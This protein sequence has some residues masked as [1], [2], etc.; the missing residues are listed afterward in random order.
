MKVIA[1]VALIS[2]STGVHAQARAVQLTRKIEMWNPAWSPDG[3]T[4]VFESTLDGESSIYTIRAD[5]S[6]LARLTD[7]SFDSGQ[8]TWSPDGRRIVYSSN[9]D[10]Q[11][12]IY[13]MNADGSAQTKITSMQSGG[14]Y[15]SS[16][17]PDGRLIVFQGRPN[18]AQT[19]DRIY[20]IGAD[21][22]RFKQ[23][24]DTTHG[25]EGPRWSRDGKTI[26]FRWV[27]Y[28]KWLWEQMGPADMNAANAGARRMSIRPDGSGLSPVPQVAEPSFSDPAVPEDA[29]RSP[30]GGMFAYTKNV[31]G[32]NALYIYSI[33]T[34]KERMILGGA[35]A[36][37]V[38][39]LRTANAVPVTDT[40]DTFESP[41]AG[42]ELRRG[43]GASV[44][45]SVRQIGAH[46]WET[47]DTWFDSSGRVTARQSTRTIN[48]SLATELESV[49][50]DGDSATLL[51]NGNRATG[52]VA[53]QGQAPR[54]IDGALR[55][56]RYAG[57][58]VIGAIATSKPATGKIFYLPSASLYGASP[59]E[60]RT[61]SIRVVR[62]DTLYRGTTAIPTVVLERTGGGLVWASEE[63][64]AAVA[65]RGSAGPDRWW[66]HIQRGVAPPRMR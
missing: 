18:N 36:G 6:G 26:T 45:H 48:G 1:F 63:T 46:R 28:P 49:R 3:R 62:R 32:W 23:L 24:T 64:G 39:Y 53:P 40:I 21:G 11:S 34:R 27:P 58:F 31:D 59:L 44:I 60:S 13:V 29:E 10:R 4:I 65:A 42:G 66:W 61:D 37:P 17:S 50:A 8:P 15:Q 30:N 20:V 57:A 56:E 51:I 47:Q 2:V 14:Y 33:A 52:W 22:T 9:R 35:G 16:F 55:E 25:A 38:G 19:R 41:R 7:P 5:G 54:L 12:N 43:N